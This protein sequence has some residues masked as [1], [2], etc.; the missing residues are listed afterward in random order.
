MN[1]MIQLVHHLRATQSWKG[2]HAIN[3]VH[4]KKP[5]D[6]WQHCEVEVPGTRYMSYKMGIHR[7][8]HYKMR[9]QFF[10]QNIGLVSSVFAQFP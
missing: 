3:T 8:I 9:F 2:T 7:I 1:L 10:F 4:P 6:A 5:T